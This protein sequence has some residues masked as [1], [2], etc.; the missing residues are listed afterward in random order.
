MFKEDGFDVLCEG[1]EDVEMKEAV[2]EMG[3]K[4]E[5][6]YYYSRPLSEKDFI[7][8]MKSL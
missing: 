5:Q 2:E 6:G 7:S 1:I 4:Y 3:A 8:Y